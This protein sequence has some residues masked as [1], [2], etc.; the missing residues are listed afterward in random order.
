[1]TPPSR[2]CRDRIKRVFPTRCAALRPQEMVALSDGV[3]CYGSRHESTN[4]GNGS[5]SKTV[6]SDAVGDVAIGVPHD[7]ESTFE[8]QIVKKRQRRL[9]DVERSSCADL[10]TNSRDSSLDDDRRSGESAHRHRRVGSRLAQELVE[11][12]PPLTQV[13]RYRRCSARG[14]A[15]PLGLGAENMV[16]SCSVH[17]LVEAAAEAVLSE[18]APSL[19]HPRCQ[20]TASEAVQQRDRLGLGGV[21]SLRA[22]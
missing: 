16:T 13:E 15:R 2:L 5:R 7:R 20:K 18:P 17:V 19:G 9:T 3:G 1:M 10:P 14:K 12:R 6:I 8:P 11:D 21:V 4:V 22:A